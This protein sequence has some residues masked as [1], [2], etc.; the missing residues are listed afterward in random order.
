MGKEKQVV[1]S[2]SLSPGISKKITDFKDDKGRSFS[3]AVEHMAKKFF[4]KPE[5]NNDE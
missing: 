1:H 2:V 5:K 3:N 4:K